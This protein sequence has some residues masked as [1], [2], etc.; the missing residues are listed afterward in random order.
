MKKNV[1][2][3]ALSLFLLI[4]IGNVF[5]QDKYGA[6]PD[7]C[8]TNLSIFYEYAKVKNY[9]A[10]YEPWK[11]CFDNCPAAHIGIYSQGLKIAEDR[12][13]KAAPADKVA[14]GK[15]IDEVFAK[16]L[17]YFPDNAGKVY[18]DW[19]I[20]MEERGAPKEKVFE[21]LEAAFKAD[22]ADMSVK[23]L[24]KYYQEITDRNKDTN[25][26]KVFDTYDDVMDAVNEKINKITQEVDKINAIDSTGAKLNTTQK[27]TLKNGQINLNALG[28]VQVVLDDILGE[29]ATCDR[30]IPLYEKN[31]E[32]NKTDSKWLRRAASKLNE[33]ECTDDPIFPKLVEAYVHAEPSPEAY[34]YYARVLEER[35]NKSEAL[36]YIKKAVDIETNPY[37]K[38]GYLYDIAV[39]YGKNSPT[40]AASY[41]RQALSYQP[42]MGRAYLLIANAYAR[43]ANSC[44]T[45]EFSKR[46]VFVAAANKAAQAKR[47]DPSVSARADKAINSYLANA[48][49][50]K[51]VFIKGLQS[52]AP[53]KIGCWINETVRIP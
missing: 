23:N 16:R 11:W 44:G 20:S 9:D 31:F 6:E 53:F 28:Q 40:T 19:A 1:T 15:L 26:Q 39:T 21:K 52:G 38:A 17:Q 51:D 35:G 4:G 18:S 7:K 30:L 22:P 29:V 49:S 36:K 32:A 43:S 8:K 50:K 5:A 24:A 46:M 13:E 45:D 48:P 47:V 10:A 34:I 37:K 14:A 42:S 2:T 25:V 12:Y 3:L 33:K 27:R 41:A